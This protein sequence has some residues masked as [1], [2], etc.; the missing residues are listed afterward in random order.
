[1]PVELQPVALDLVPRGSRK[2]TH[3]A[4]YSTVI[5]ILYLAATRADQVVVVLRAMR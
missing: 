5:E 1:V 4:T 2:L 3:E